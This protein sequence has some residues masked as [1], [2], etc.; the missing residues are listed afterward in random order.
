MLRAL[1]G[2]SLGIAISGVALAAAP[3]ERLPVAVM[4]MGEAQTL[5]E[6]VKVVEAV[7]SELTRTP[8]ARPL[9]SA[10][11]RRVL[12]EGGPATLAAVRQARGDAL[13]VQAK[14]ADA[15]REYEAAEQLLLTDVPIPVTQQRLGAVERNLL[16]IYDQ[17]GRTEDAA[18]AA[19][20]LSWTAGSNEDVKALLGRHLHGRAWQ[21]AFPPLHIETQPQGALVYRD[22]QPVG[23]APLDV[24]GG[25]PLVDA[26]DV[27][28]PGYRRG[29]L[30]LGH[31]APSVTV[32]LTREDR[33][34]AFVDAVRARA[35]EAPPG[36]VA[37][38]G[39]RV[40]AVRVLVLAPDGDKLQARWLDVAR[41]KWAD[42]AI[43]VDT[44]EPQAMAR[45]AAY[46][47]PAP[48][49]PAPAVVA[50]APPPEKKKSKWGAWGKWYTWV[51]AG[52][53]LLLVGGLLIAQNVGSDSLTI[54]VTNQP[55]QP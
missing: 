40:G 23:A 14:M 19:E 21:P 10:E 28:A 18:R 13:F 12:V 51:A 30:E 5:D 46:V 4:W 45:L 26:I 38:L 17:L 11:E 47:A 8:G 9:D 36:D 50:Q 37:A 52:G 35:P 24:N 54:K 39:R 29:H 1:I 6:G 42:K 2:V 3:V 34:G 48:P 43:R 16:V 15:A 31:G 55:T 27:E 22:L 44:A 32:T 41:A 7:N 33:L 20:R 49:A 53:V 25:D